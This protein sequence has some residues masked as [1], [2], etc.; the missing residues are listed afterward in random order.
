[1]I[2]IMFCLTRLPSFS[3]EALQRR[4]REQHAP[5]VASHAAALRIRRYV[6]THT[7]P[8][9]TFAPLAAL[10]GGL[11]AYDGVAELWFVSVEDVMAGGAS[12]EGRRAGRI[13]LED[14]KQFI[15]FKSSPI[16]FGAEH[17]IIPLGGG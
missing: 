8:D 17:E 12:P 15:E 11:P 1:M 2:K 10:R 6:Q 9:A 14:E 16:W 13:L 4:W 3:R 7:L 5:L